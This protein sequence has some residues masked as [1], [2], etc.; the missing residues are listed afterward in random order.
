M[1]GW[2]WVLQY[3]LLYQSGILLLRFLLGP[4][5]IRERRLFGWTMLVELAG[6]SFDEGS[7]K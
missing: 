1:G 6:E 5:R 4:E 2:A 3:F 7:D